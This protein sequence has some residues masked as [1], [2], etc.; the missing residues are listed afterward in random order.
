M[1]ADCAVHSLT[2]L[3][4]LDRR[5]ALR[6]HINLTV[7]V[8][9]TWTTFPSLLSTVRVAELLEFATL[10]PMWLVDATVGR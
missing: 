6:V 10:P 7:I 9:G 8:S 5:C 1:R 2:P 3:G 4:V